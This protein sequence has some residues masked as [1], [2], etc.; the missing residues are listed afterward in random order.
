MTP[1][2]LPHSDMH[3]SKRICR[4]P[5][6]IAA[7]HVLLRLLAPRHPSCALC[8]LINLFPLLQGNLMITETRFL[9][10]P[11][12]AGPTQTVLSR[13]RGRYAHFV[14]DSAFFASLGR[15]LSF[16]FTL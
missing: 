3:G 14:S 11:V 4:S 13:P 16:L 10:G 7:C 5:C 1:A 12:R 6:L 9:T 15:K 8:S 2:R